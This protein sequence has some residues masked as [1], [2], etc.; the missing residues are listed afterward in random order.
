MRPLFPRERAA[1]LGSVFYFA[2]A[3]SA[4]WLLNLTADLDLPIVYS[5]VF[6]AVGYLYGWQGATVQA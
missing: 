3:A 1:W 4:A 2:V 6:G 5:A